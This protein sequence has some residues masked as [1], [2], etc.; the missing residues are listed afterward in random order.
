[1][2]ET[3]GRR[4]P[5]RR[6]RRP[7]TVPLADAA[8]GA[9]GGAD[10]RRPAAR[11]RRPWPPRSATRPARSPRRCTALAEEYAEQGRGFDLRNVAGGW[12]YYT[13][14]EYAAGRGAVRR[15]TGSRP[16]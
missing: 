5:S 2:T 16:G 6:P 10:G 1:M 11:P 14:E 13:R 15:S 3:A 8:A 7:S 9:G 4:R 12:R